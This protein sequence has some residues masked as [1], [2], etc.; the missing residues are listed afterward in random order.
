MPNIN[1]NRVTISHSYNRNPFGK[2]YYEEYLNKNKTI[3]QNEKYFINRYPL[4]R[5]DF[6][7]KIKLLN[8]KNNTVQNNAILNDNF[9][10]TSNDEKHEQGSC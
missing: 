9:N 8:S 10:E 3:L 1:I 7:E 6:M 2:K 5:P 4:T